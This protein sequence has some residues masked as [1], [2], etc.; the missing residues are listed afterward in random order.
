MSVS[1]ISDSNNYWLQ[2]MQTQKNQ[3]ERGQSMQDI[4]ELLSR[5]EDDAS[6]SAE[7]MSRTKM[8][9]PPEE[10]DFENMSDEDLKGYLQ[11]MQDA[12]GFIP[13]IEEGVQASELTTEQLE[14]VRGELSA[15][16]NRRPEM[17]GMQG[18]P[19][20]PM[21]NGMSGETSDEDITSILSAIQERT[22]VI[23]GIEESEETDV[24]QLTNEQ[25]QT[26]WDS[27]LEAMQQRMLD[28]ASKMYT[29]SA[30]SA[31]LADMLL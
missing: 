29:N 12:T 16:K 5:K 18:P 9:Q 2:R 6:I 17:M 25:K 28:Y 4:I 21:M 31:N 11:Q 3:E 27:V 10:M 15:V 14:T 23:P 8:P 20:P 19:P 7:G 1:S 13:G 26:A 22:G 30:N 24:S